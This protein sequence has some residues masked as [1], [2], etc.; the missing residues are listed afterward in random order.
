[1]KDPAKDWTKALI[2]LQ[3]WDIGLYIVAATVI[4]V[5]AGPDVKSPALGS[6][7]PIIKK[8]AWGIAIP[9]VSPLPNLPPPPASLYQTLTT[10]RSSLQVLS[11]V[12]LPRNTSS[13]A[14][15]EAQNT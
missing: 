8:V 6:A 1:M 3:T 4:Y 11:T 13:C 12:T 9:T 2:F 15:S 14:A 7:G 5:Y 10:S